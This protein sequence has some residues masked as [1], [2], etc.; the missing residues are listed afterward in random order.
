MVGGGGSTSARLHKA[1]LRGILRACKRL[2]ETPQ[3]RAFLS[4]EGTHNTKATKASDKLRVWLG[5]NKDA[6]L[7]IPQPSRRLSATHT[8]LREWRKAKENRDEGKDVDSVFE[9]LRILRNANKE[10]SRVLDYSAVARHKIEVLSSPLRHQLPELS[11]VNQIQTGNILVS[12]PM[13]SCSWFQRSLVLV[14]S[15]DS[16]GTTGLIINQALSQHEKGR[17]ITSDWHNLLKLTSK[18]V[19]D[20]ANAANGTGTGKG[21]RSVGKSREGRRRSSFVRRIQKGKRAINL[22]YDKL[23][24]RPESWGGPVFTTFSCILH[25]LPKIFQG[26]EEVFPGIYIGGVNPK[27]ALYKPVRHARA[28]GVSSGIDG[29]KIKCFNGIT[30]WHPGQLEQEL[31]EG[32]WIM[33]KMDESE[34]TSTF[35]E[36]L[37]SDEIFKGCQALSSRESRDIMWRSFLQK[38]GGEFAALSSIPL[39][40]GEKEKDEDEDEEDEKATL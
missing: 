35:L 6:R 3:L 5:G 33:V 16:S 26:S 39:I 31:D 34:A 38:L 29:S 25:T 4:L 32:T 28:E 13:L 30:S 15:S 11:P 37:I 12:H 24:K 17:G 1:L 23:R 20:A 9:L 21:R 19:A 8:V 10:A 18:C 40:G 22:I 27:H 36:K 7:Y 2:D 14:T